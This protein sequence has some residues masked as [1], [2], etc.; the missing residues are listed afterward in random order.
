MSDKV[1]LWRCRECEKWS[2]AQRD[3]IAHKRWYHPEGAE[4]WVGWFVWCGPFDR[5]EA[6]HSDTEPRAALPHVGQPVDPSAREA[7]LSRPSTVFD[8]DD[9][10]V[11]F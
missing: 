7:A 3:P 6:R 1:Q 5:W 8:P 4:P 10:G 2:H 9:A 11:P